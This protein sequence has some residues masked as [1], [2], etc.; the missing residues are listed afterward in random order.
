MRKTLWF[1]AVSAVCGAAALCPT[2]DAQAPAATAAA[3]HPASLDDT[4]IV[5]ALYVNRWASQSPRRMR[6]LIAIAGSTEINA[7]VSDM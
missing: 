5:R 4:T 6:Q 2:L 3:V 1:V 7:L